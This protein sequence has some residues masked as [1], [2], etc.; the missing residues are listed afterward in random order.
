MEHREIQLTE[1]RFGTTRRRGDTAT[2]RERIR[3]QKQPVTY[4]ISYCSP[5]TAYHLLKTASGN[6]PGTTRE[7]KDRLAGNRRGCRIPSDGSGKPTARVGRSF[8]QPGTERR[9]R[10]GEGGSYGRDDKGYPVGILNYKSEARSTKQ[11]RSTNSPMFKT[12]QFRY[13]NFGF[14][15]GGTT[16][17]ARP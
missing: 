7:F 17:D 13:S 2:R 9:S 3:D 11:I 16:E 1:G 6:T 12:I 4:N 14:A 15:D 10:F 5:F 8:T